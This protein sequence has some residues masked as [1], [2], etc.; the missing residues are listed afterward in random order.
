[1]KRI[2]L[3]LLIFTYT[4]NC[5]QPPEIQLSKVNRSSITDIN[6]HSQAYLFYN[7][8][9]VDSVTLNRKNLIL[10]TNWIVHIDARLSLKKVLPK[11]ALLHKKRTKKSIHSK[12]GMKNYFS[13]LDLSYKRLAFIDYSAFQF[14]YPDT[15]SK[16]YIKKSPE[17]HIPLY[18]L[19]INFDYLNQITVDSNPVA[20]SELNSFLKEQIDFASE[21]KKTLLY[22]NFDERLSFEEYLNNYLLISEVV[23][24]QIK[25][26]EQQFVYNYDKLPDCNCKL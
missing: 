3:L 17:F 18:N 15:H 12:E 23:N 25:I 10:N 14:K 6:N 26:A 2:F 5:S 20:V 7:I 24:E 9:E 21:G 1:M 13:V 11:L 22:L 16:F 19:S 8:K 4:V